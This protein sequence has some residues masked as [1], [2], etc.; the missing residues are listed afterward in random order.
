MGANNNAIQTETETVD[1][2]ETGTVETE[3]VNN[4]VDFSAAVL[5][6]A[7]GSAEHNRAES[8]RTV[9]ACV[10]AGVALDNDVIKRLRTVFGA[11]FSNVCKAA[12]KMIG[13]GAEIVYNGDAADLLTK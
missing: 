12:A 10:L 11:E 9:F 3:T 6:C 7:L 13:R 4:V 2:G 1:N 5:A 8:A